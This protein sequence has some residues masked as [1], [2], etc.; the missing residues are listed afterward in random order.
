[1]ST[2]VELFSY[3]RLYAGLMLAELGF[4][5]SRFNSFDTMFN[6]A[7]LGLTITVNTIRFTLSHV[8]T[9]DLGNN[10]TIE[11]GYRF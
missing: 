5:N 10:E 4:N 9:F 3:F 1:L 2:G 7:S 6:S 11:I 8:H